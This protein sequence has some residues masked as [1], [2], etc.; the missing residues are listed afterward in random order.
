MVTPICMLVLGMRLS[1]S[2]FKDLFT[3]PTVFI[4]CLFKL[5]VFPLF[6]LLLVYTAIYYILTLKLILLKYNS[7]FERSLFL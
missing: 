6:V 5:V 3:R 7:N 1:T 4:S 2:K